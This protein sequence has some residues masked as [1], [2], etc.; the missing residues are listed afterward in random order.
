[1]EIGVIEKAPA[2][3]VA[4]WQQ[5]YSA[6]AERAVIGSMLIDAACVK[7]LMKCLEGEDFFIQTNQDIFETVRRMYVAAKPIDGVTVA[8]ELERA[9]KYSSETRSYLVQC[10]E[11][12]PTS[13]NAMEYAQIVRKKA[14]KRRFTQA[15]MDAL[16]GEDD[17][18]AAVAA[19]CHQKMRSRRGGRLKTMSDAMSEAMNSVAG[20]KEGRIDTGFPLLDATLKGLWPGQLI[21]VGARPGCGKSALCMEMTEHA[22]RGGKTVLHITAEMLA[23]EVGERLLAKRTEGVTMDQLIDGVPET[24]EDLWMNIAYTASMEAKLPV[25]FYDGPDVTVSR[26]RE[27]AL[28]ID[29]LKMIVVDYLGL[30]I[31]EKDKKAE[32]RNLELGGIS[33]ELKLLASELEIPIVAAAQLSRT[34]NETDKPKLSSLR[35]SGELEQN[36]VKVIFLWKTDPG[37]ETQVGCTVAKNRRGRTGDVN[38]YFDGSKMTFT[39]MSYRTDN[40]EPA[41]KFHQRPRRRRL[42]MG[43][44]EGD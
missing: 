8:D 34:V 21:L 27:L 36:A 29:D 13:A 35:D 25:Y 14:E 44:V 12:T 39:E 10:M 31:G 3:E 37:D 20:K 33:R 22:A 15:V 1:M 42:E 23:G 17:T 40:D 6:D 41:D 2:A 16:T 9:G 18:Q 11:I 5:D 19:I 32:N 26:I 7:D 4:L 24:D 43:T 30:M 38:F 28:G